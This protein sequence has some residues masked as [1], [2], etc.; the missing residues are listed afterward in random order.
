ME[1]T[2]IT[3]MPGHDARDLVQADAFIIDLYMGVNNDAAG[4]RWTVGGWW[5][6][7]EHG[8][9]DISGVVFNFTRLDNLAKGLHG[10]KV[11]PLASTLQSPQ[12][13]GLGQPAAV[14]LCSRSSPVDPEKGHQS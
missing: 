2:L 10:A 6:A 11:P 3:L 13:P 4:F 5:G 12:N 9:N 7:V 1:C 8:N 14:L